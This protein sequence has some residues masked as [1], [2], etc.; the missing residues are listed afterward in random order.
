MPSLASKASIHWS[1]PRKPHC[2]RY[3]ARLSGDRPR[4]GSARSEVDHE[5][6]VNDGAVRAHGVRQAQG[7]DRAAVD[8]DVFDVPAR[9]L[10][11]PG[12]PIHSG[13]RVPRMAETAE[14][15]RARAVELDALREQHRRCLELEAV[16]VARTA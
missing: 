6:G 11:P 16:V 15:L 14:Y 5:V 9:D 1:R 4:V 12:K 2:S 10:A 7:A 3:S 13:A 8:V